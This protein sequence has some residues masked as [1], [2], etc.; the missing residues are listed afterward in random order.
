VNASPAPT[1]SATCVGKPGCLCTPSAATSELPLGPSVTHTSFNPHV[2][3]SQLAAAAF[4]FDL[5]PRSAET[6]DNSSSF[7]F[8]MSALFADS[9]RMSAEKKDCRKFTSKT[10]TALGGKFSRNNR[11]VFR[12]RPER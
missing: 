2:C 4:V 5:Y 11:I 3:K 1:V 12:E 9:R 8:M 7:T 6:L 10:L